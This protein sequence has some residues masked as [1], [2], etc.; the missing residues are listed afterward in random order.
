M[1]NF[2]DYRA[3]TSQEVA[4]TRWRCSMALSLPLFS[5]SFLALRILLPMRM[6]EL[7]F[8]IDGQRASPGT[9]MG[10]R[11]DYEWRVPAVIFSS[12]LH[13]AQ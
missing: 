2:A 9:G 7:D 5:I 10:I 12:L 6:R 13:S 8:S 3:L 11:D 4:L 1:S